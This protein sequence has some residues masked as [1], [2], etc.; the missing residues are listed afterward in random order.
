MIHSRRRSEDKGALDLL[1]EATSLLRLAPAGLL[2]SY[3]AGSLPFVLGLLFFWADMSRG[4]FARQHASDA[5]LGMALLYLWMK[6]W[7]AVFA[8]RLRAR[9]SSTA[10]SSPGSRGWARLWWSQAAH[11]PYSLFALPVA[12]LITIPF[13]W[14]YAFYQS[15]TVCGSFAEARRQSMLWPAQN[16]ALIG[17]FLLLALFAFLNVAAAL[18]TLPLLL[19]ALFGIETAYSRSPFS[20]VNSTFFAATAGL[21][22]LAVG[23]LVKAAYVLRCFYGDSLRTGED[24]KVE[25][26]SA[27]AAWRRTAAAVVAALG[28]GLASMPARAGAELL[29]TPEARPAAPGAAPVSPDQIERSI[30]AVLERREFSWRL[31]REAPARDEAQPGL[32]TRFFRALADATRHGLQAL[33]TLIDWIRAWLDR[34]FGRPQ[35]SE[36]AESEGSAWLS[37]VQWLLGGLLILVACAAA[38][39][40][41][42][43]RRSRRQAQAVSQGAGVAAELP[44]DDSAAARAPADHWLQRARQLASQGDLRQALRA[45]FLASL[46]HL[47]HLEL[48]TLA[49]FKSNRDYETELRRR[50]RGR[51]NVAALF[52][53]NVAIFEG[54]WYGRRE[55]TEDLLLAFSDNFDRLR[56]DAQS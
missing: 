2:A 41:W 29:E 20:L 18:L 6:G 15:L 35:G 44:A 38:V 33:R 8:R 16:H 23:P 40:F 28:M 50:G 13:G 37:S 32:L 3:Y 30:R 39:F 55:T 24:L 12:L 43:S 49:R 10:S 36:A 4:S 14:V 19:A 11:Q 1:E 51:P 7:Q 42:R 25:L 56:A 5:A 31:P 48:L 17:M 54:V 34:L 22:Y 47:A 46:S 27:A 45:L 53:E 21:T 26:K 52:A 9:L